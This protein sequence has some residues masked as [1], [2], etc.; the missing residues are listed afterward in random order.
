[1]KYWFPIDTEAT[2]TYLDGVAEQKRLSDKL[3]IIRDAME[4]DSGEA[5][6]DY[7]DL[8]SIPDIWTAHR[9]YN[10]MLFGPDD[11]LDEGNTAEDSGNA[12]E[13]GR[14]RKNGVMARYKASIIKQ[15]RA[16]MTLILIGNDHY[17]LEIKEKDI[18]ADSI[19]KRDNGLDRE[20]REIMLAVFMAR[21]MLALREEE[22]EPPFNDEMVRVYYIV[23]SGEEMP[24]AISSPTTY[25]VPA[26]DAWEAL[27]GFEKLKWIENPPGGKGYGVR[28]DFLG[29]LGYPEAVALRA[30]LRRILD[31]LPDPYP[32]QIKKAEIMKRMLEDFLD[33]PV[34][35]QSSNPHQPDALLQK[36][37]YY[38]VGDSKTRDILPD[39]PVLGGVDPA[40]YFVSQKQ[41]NAGDQKTYVYFYLPMP[42]TDYCRAL[43]ETGKAESG[44]PVSYR[45]EVQEDEGELKSAEAM[46]TIGG[47][48]I[49]R[50]YSGDELVR[51]KPNQVSAVALWP[52]ENIKGWGEYHAFRYDQAT[53]DYVIEPLETATTYDIPGQDDTL[54][55]YYLM[56]KWPGFWA[57]K[58]RAAAGDALGYIRSRRGTV[59]LPNETDTHTIAL[60]F[61]TSSTMM[62]RKKAGE[63]GYEPVYGNSFWA[64]PIS[65]PDQ[66]AYLDQIVSCFIPVN[67]GDNE[68]VPYQTM[69]GK[70]MR[71]EARFPGL[72]SGR[73]IYFSNIASAKGSSIG[74]PKV[75][76]VSGLKW[77]AVDSGDPKHF[78][79][80]TALFAALD[81]RRKG[82]K[83]LEIIASYPGA[84]SEEKRLGYIKALKEIVQD[85]SRKTGLAGRV[86]EVTESLAVA[87]Y[88]SGKDMLGLNFCSV[89]IGGGTSD[90]F[91]CYKPES[92]KAKWQGHG[93]SLRIGAREIFLKSFC[94]DR[95]LLNQ[96][97]EAGAGSV[98]VQKLKEQYL[99]PDPDMSK[100]RRQTIRIEELTAS[101]FKPEDVYSLIEA[102]LSF[103]IQIDDM[104][105]PAADVLRSIAVSG[106]N[107]VALTNLRLRI[108]YYVGAVVYYAGMLARIPGKDGS[109]ADIEKLNIEFAGNGSK[110]VR[111]IG[112]DTS[113]VKSFMKTMFSA[114]MRTEASPAAVTFSE[115]PKHE[116]AN[117]A[118]LRNSF[119]DSIKQADVIIAGETHSSDGSGE[120][121]E[122]DEMPLLSSGSE[123]QIRHDELKAFLKSFNATVGRVVPKTP[124]SLHFA[125]PEGEELGFENAM[126]LEI[127]AL[128]QSDE[129]MKPFFLIGVEL[130]DKFALQEETI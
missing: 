113:A 23:K 18:S 71:S 65:Y 120:R 46:V 93:S 7:D 109:T 48:S 75:K 25:L 38:F 117:G 105:E 44:M 13:G 32:R 110:I 128:T 63:D 85:I 74:M 34:V 96:I 98:T 84:M 88:L 60:D 14:A 70:D 52:R 102:L 111:W 31:G 26:A 106:S 112:D 57:L 92:Q 80:E 45:C 35:V 37:F 22:K 59:E 68:G 66:R 90:I 19:N 81:A 20:T 40:C 42:V 27:G 86:K 47:I 122:T 15:W 83:K 16:I 69:L 73:W 104:L 41:T 3:K 89:D 121:A 62:Y 4:I 49:R 116:V 91:I 50:S 76:I 127:D 33:D 95:S 119:L 115:H 130:C 124:G 55:R 125:Y 24:I 30:K 87:K 29:K 21:P 56:D 11:A 1:M 107:R 78:L 99:V 54:H 94:L 82:C 79:R 36:K 67:S 9:I 12:N 53:V 10:M 118:M 129:E 123:C 58:H 39:D 64:A 103:N 100:S 17:G 61:G 2:D 97:L 72:L 108:A 114:G 28:D 77:R 5:K 43:L 126:E 8:R 101:R 51:M 6:I